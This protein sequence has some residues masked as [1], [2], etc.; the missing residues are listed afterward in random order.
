M[1]QRVIDPTEG[2]LLKK[3]MLY[4]L[5][6][7]LTG[8]L[9]LLF[10]AADLIVVGQ[11]CGNN[12]VAAVGATGA[13]TGLL[14][15]LF[16]GMSVGVGVSCTH[17]LGAKNDEVLHKTIHTAVPTAL[18]SGLFIGVI[19]FVFSPGLLELMDTPE[20]VLG[21]SS[22]YMRIYFVGMPFTLLC[23]FGIAILRAAGDNRSP[24]IYLTLSGALNAVMNVIFV[25]VFS[26][27]V[28][29]VA[30]ATT[31]SGALATVLVM[32]TLMRRKDACRFRF[33]QMRI[34]KKPLLKIITIGLPAGIQSSLFAISNVL[35]QSSINSFGTAAMSGN[36]ASGNIEGFLSTGLDSFTQTAM[37]F[38]GLCV[39]ARRYD[40]VPK[41]LR[42]CLGCVVA[43]GLPLGAL[44]YFNGRTLLGIYITDS[45]EAINYGMQRMVF[46]AIPWVLGGCMNIASGV[47][48]GMG[49]SVQPMIS[50]VLGVCV[51]RIFW[52]YTIFAVPELHTYPCLM[53]SY[54]VSWGLTF[55]VLMISYVLVR[56]KE[57]QLQAVPL[58]E[59]RDAEEEAEDAPVVE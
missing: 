11:F 54:P 56:R 4:S 23:N 46:M 51:F 35:I 9:Q 39:G 24:L 7:A 15:N 38:T 27:D 26:M 29:G 2:P 47:L 28:A 52:I 58:T 3:C 41:I 1:A 45:V 43:I 34:Y 8:L 12:S 40:R 13:L 22:L 36:T 30:L 5:P 44:I 21:L 10:N 6:I 50:T 59:I 42:T 31:L 20:E 37:N 14:V 33:S 49:R 32:L 18:I 19:G 25:R 55:G 53:L 57:K 16:I 17:A 48:R